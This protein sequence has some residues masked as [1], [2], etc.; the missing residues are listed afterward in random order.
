MVHTGW[1]H[2]VAEQVHRVRISVHCSS[3]LYCGF[4]WTVCALW[5][6][7]ALS[8]CTL[9]TKPPAAATEIK[10]PLEER[11]NAPFEKH[12]LPL[13]GPGPEKTRGDAS[14]RRG[15][16]EGVRVIRA[17]PGCGGARG[18]S[19]TGERFW[20]RDIE[21]VGLSADPSGAKCPRQECVWTKDK[22]EQK[23]V[24]SKLRP[25]SDF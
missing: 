8:N 5:P 2:S 6:P 7:G 21:A 13:Q 11:S 22:V 25:S 19:Q 20:G 14:Q 1:I 16:R 3:E 4:L 12:R 18:I 23:K 15:Q 10:D 9:D 17:G 24:G